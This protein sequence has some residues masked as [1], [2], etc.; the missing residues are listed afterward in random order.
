MGSPF[1]VRTTRSGVSYVCKCVIK[2][3]HRVDR[4]Q[5]DPEMTSVTGLGCGAMDGAI[6]DFR[7]ETTSVADE[8]G[9]AALTTSPHWSIG[10]NANGG[11]VA[12]V[13]ARAMS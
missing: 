6:S 9:T 7:R 8:H 3:A 13:V 4:R 12:A 2:Y 11:Y 10:T 5:L 1:C